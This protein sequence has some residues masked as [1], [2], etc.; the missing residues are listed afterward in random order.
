MADGESKNMFV[1]ICIAQSIC[2]FTILIGIL[3]TKF[4]FV[5]QWQKMRS[6]FINNILEQTKITALTQ[7]DFNP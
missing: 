3:A 2:I 7:E 5:N 6:F 1:A 4:F